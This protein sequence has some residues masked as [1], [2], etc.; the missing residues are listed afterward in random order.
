MKS[1]WPKKKQYFFGTRWL[2]LIFL[3]LPA[4]T[5]YELKD[6]G[7]GSGGGSGTST[8]Y[9]ITGISGEQSAG[10]L[11]GTTYDL[12]SG[13]VFTN[14]ANVPSAPSFTNPA[15]Y[16]NKLLVTLVPGENPSDTLYAIAISSDNFVT[17]SY[18]QS[19][20]TVGATL[21]AEDYQ[22]YTN[23]GGVSGTLIIGL[24]ANTTYK[25][26][27]KA[28]QG[29]KT[30]T[31]YGPVATQSTVGAKLSF[32]I[33]VSASDTE[34]AAPFATN[35]GN[36]NPGN[37]TNSTEQIWIDFDTNAENG[38]RVY[39]KGANAGLQS[40]RAGY[41]I[42]SVSGN[43][44]ALQEGFG[45]QGVSATQSAGGPFTLTPAYSLTSDNVA[46]SDTTVRE[47][48]TAPSPVANGRGR[49]LL[50]A[51]ASSVTPAASDYQ[52]VLTIITSASF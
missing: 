46:I 14:Q 10:K 33:D 23:W 7:F 47:V 5:S 22:T 24:S 51:K 38:G 12:G 37:V 39:I 43:L 34:T 13:M 26:K 9:G 1:F 48:F 27:V 21:G 8:N 16:Y 32:D 3:A 17:T 42:S 25:V 6:F 41:T 40:V 4:S 2:L 29:S 28:I 49:L 19:D 44:A 30:E 36:L 35:L 15:N 11:S 18:V 31:D 45:L 52:E 20:D 50:K